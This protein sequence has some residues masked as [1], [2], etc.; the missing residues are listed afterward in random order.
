MSDSNP[1]PR[2]LTEA[3]HSPRFSASA[4]PFSNLCLARVFES[5]GIIGSAFCHC[6]DKLAWHS[7][8]NAATLST[9]IVAKQPLALVMLHR[10]ENTHELKFLNDLVGV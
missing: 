3:G 7:A 1:V 10:M 9:G 8:S 4:D 2:A 5:L 6:A